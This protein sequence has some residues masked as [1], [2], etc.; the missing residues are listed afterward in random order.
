MT[1]AL[2]FEDVGKTYGR[3]QALRG[4]SLTVRAGAVTAV[5]GENGAGKST[6]MKIAAGLVAP[7]RGT[8]RLP[9]GAAMEHGPGQ[10]I[11]QGISLVPQELT[12]CDNLTVAE[13]VLLGEFPV[14]T[15]VLDRA[16]M[17]QRA[18][19]RLEALARPHLRL[20]RPVERLTVA[21]RTFVQIARALKPSTSVLILDE[22][23]APMAE[24]ETR[25]L[26]DVVRGLTR[27]GIAVLYISHRMDE[28]FALA[29]RLV[30]L[31]DGLKV[32]DADTAAIDRGDAIEAMVG[33]RD[34]S[35]GERTSTPGR[36][37]LQ[38]DGLRSRKLHDVS[39]S[40]HAGEIVGV[41][42]IAG[43]GREDLGSALVGADPR[44]L[45]TVSVEG[46]TLRPGRIR[47]SI[48][49]GVGYVPPERRS[50]GLLME[51]SVRANMSLA[52]LPKVTK[53]GFL[54]R[55]RERAQTTGLV[56]RL[57]IKAADVDAPVGNLSGGNQQKVL[58]ARALAATDRL[59]VL[60][61]PTRG[62]DIATKAEIY[63]FLDELSEQGVAVVVIGSDLEE[64]ALV[65]HRV[66]VIGSG[67]VAADLVRPS[68]AEIARAAN[69]ENPA[70][71]E[72]NET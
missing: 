39:M 63:R 40:V 54:D 44:A 72:R 10:A 5:M 51:G 42:G 62:V 28:V 4:V 20:D 59:L 46:R 49:A 68:Q 71:R 66:V 7:D 52:T 32:L 22:P 58:L 14:K 9:S 37:V 36:V 47:E 25:D 1:E 6:L 12:L 61:E 2:R 53:R 69:P 16:E 65:A 60:E 57:R 48:A 30:V 33:G 23:T 3:V 43:S 70:H 27:N 11:A 41:Y 26:F 21:E 31:R 24:E 18:G 13:N 56:Q 8:V 15:G 55:R 29:D 67:T 17:R 19:A 64:I 50:Q 38:V 35:A 34:L 45:G